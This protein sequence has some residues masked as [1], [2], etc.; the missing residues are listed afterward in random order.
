MDVAMDRPAEIAE[1][2]RAG[3]G[4]NPHD[5]STILAPGERVLSCERPVW[6]AHA[7]GSKGGWVLL[8]GVCSVAAGLALL[9]WLLD[10]SLHDRSG[11]ATLFA[12]M[13]ATG[14]F[15]NVIVLY[16]VITAL[17]TRHVITDR[18]IMVVSG[19]GRN[20]RVVFQ[21]GDEPLTELTVWKSGRWPPSLFLG[22]AMVKPGF[23]L[24]TRP[25]LYGVR[26]GEQAAALIARQRYAPGK[27]A[28]W[29]DESPGP[30]GNLVP[31]VP[32]DALPASLLPHLAEGEEVVWVGQPMPGPFGWR[33]FR[34][35]WPYFALWGVFT[36]PGLLLDLF[37]W[38]NHWTGR[39]G[40]GNPWITLV[41]AIIT[42]LPFLVGL[43]MVRWRARRASSVVYAIT[44]RRALML[45]PFARTSHF[46]VKHIGPTTVCT[47][48]VTGDS[49]CGNILFE[50]PNPSMADRATLDAGFIGIPNPLDVACILR[51][52]AWTAEFEWR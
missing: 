26:N 51:E 31:A 25:A 7:M 41:L 29:L 45:V 9:P 38:A 20:A 30:Y 42:T 22:A 2:N 37:H 33:M 13:A 10:D 23:R 21:W 14:L 40:S 4:T 17:R 28:T 6:W 12:A 3:A 39:G 5:L 32:R 48:R 24:S 36:I 18:R 27:A 43:D 46:A 49:R 47:V 8:A 44:R 11:L 50:G 52:Q 15:L 34:A 35:P 16:R 1:P 19:R